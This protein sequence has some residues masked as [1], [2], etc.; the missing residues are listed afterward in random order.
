MEV[1][2]E[3]KFQ[4]PFTK[5]I[6]GPTGAGKTFYLKQL[7][8][9]HDTHISPPLQKV[10]ICYGESQPLYNQIATNIPI[11][12]QEGFS[13]EILDHC[14]K[15]SL[16][17]LDDVLAE[18]LNNPLVADLFTKISHHRQISIIITS[19]NLY[20]KKL[21]VH[22]LNAQYLV[23]YKSPRSVDQIQVLSRQLGV[24]K[25]LTEIYQDA[26]KE[27]YSYLLID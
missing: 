11:E 3:P 13:N 22:S 1:V 16:L 17:I 25:F 10:V 7:I 5:I 26:T 4:S 14:P 12:L 18:V 20:E 2:D 21:R 8:E 27:P 19:Q 9:K 15:N 24:G 23:V 6:A